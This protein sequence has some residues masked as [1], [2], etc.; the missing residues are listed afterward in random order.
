MAV[1][2][3]MPTSGRAPWWGDYCADLPA[4]VRMPAH[5]FSRDSWSF[6]R[7]RP[8]WTRATP[9]FAGSPGTASRLLFAP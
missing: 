3:M 1:V 7:L 9:R 4:A 6:D 5:E 8:S 2:L